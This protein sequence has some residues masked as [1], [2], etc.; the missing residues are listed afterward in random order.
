[1]LETKYISTHG[2]GV[3]FNSCMVSYLYPTIRLEHSFSKCDRWACSSSSSSL[4]GE[5]VRNAES[6]LETQGGPGSLFSQVLLTI[7][8]CARVRTSDLESSTGCLDE[9][10]SFAIKNHAEI[11]LLICLL[12]HTCLYL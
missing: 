12:L 7:L 8:L 3:F 1:M 2:V 9:C 11:N 6:E 4:T 10:Q 5:L